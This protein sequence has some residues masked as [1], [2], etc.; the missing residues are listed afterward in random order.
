MLS[1]PLSLWT[2]W[3]PAHQAPLSAAFSRQ[4]DCRG[5]LCPPPGGL[6]DPGVQASSLS[7][8]LAGEF[9]TSSTT[10]EAH[11]GMKSKSESGIAQSGPTLCDPMACSPS[12]SSVHGNLLARIRSGLPFPSPGNFF[13]N[14]GI[15]PVSPALRADSLPSEAPGR[16]T[17]YV[18]KAV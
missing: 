10:R 2:P 12:G 7:P 16:P 9:F 18:R 14:P 15:E 5:L 17:L 4:G 11:S 6:P 8:T 1:S 3:T 13:P